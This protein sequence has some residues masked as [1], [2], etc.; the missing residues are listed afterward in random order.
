[1]KLYSQN[2][3]PP[4]RL[5]VK[6]FR[7]R[8]YPSSLVKINNNNSRLEDDKIVKVEQLKFTPNLS[9]INVNHCQ[10]KKTERKA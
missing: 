4:K 1:M 6:V 10:R 7:N 2:R 3:H 8:I 9:K 5:G